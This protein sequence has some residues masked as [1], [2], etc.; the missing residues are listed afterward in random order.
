MKENKS[1]VGVWLKW[2]RYE[3]IDYDGKIWQYENKP[4]PNPFRWDAKR[5]NAEY[6]GETAEPKDHTQT[7]IE[8]YTTEATSGAQ[9][10][11]TP[12]LLARVKELERVS[13]G[14]V[15]SN[16][17][18][19]TAQEKAESRVEALEAEVKQLRESREMVHRFVPDNSGFD[20]MRF[21][22]PNH[23]NEIGIL[24]FR[25]NPETTSDLNPTAQKVEALKMLFPWRDECE[26]MT[27]DDRDGSVWQWSVQPEDKIK[28]DFWTALGRDTHAKR[29]GEIL[30]DPE[31]SKILIRRHEQ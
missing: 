5:G 17:N 10:D 3:T 26:F 2:A 31:L 11:P 13:L 20:G 23:Q 15:N 1:N 8:R 7:L 21:V 12:D 18:I 24:G 6:V 16:V 22:V 29:V 9:A 14:L 25:D 28:G 19:R 27:V 30:P 4:T